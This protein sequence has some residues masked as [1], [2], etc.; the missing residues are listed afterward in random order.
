MKRFILPVAAAAL[1]AA[2]SDA[3]DP[4]SDPSVLPDAPSEADGA[5]RRASPGRAPPPCANS[6]P[7][8]G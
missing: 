5:A 1:V 2:C 3:N 7:S 6:G 4:S 8:S